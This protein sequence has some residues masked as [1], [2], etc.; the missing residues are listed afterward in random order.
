MAFKS[1]V[2]LSHCLLIQFTFLS[3]QLKYNHQ[4]EPGKPD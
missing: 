2:Y 3:N 1:D 4:K